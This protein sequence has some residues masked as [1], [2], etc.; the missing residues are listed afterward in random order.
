MSISG[1]LEVSILQYNSLLRSLTVRVVRGN[2][3]AARD[4][5]SLTS[6]PYFNISIR[7]DWNNVGSKRSST[8][9]G[10]FL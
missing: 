9:N 5:P 6:G 10:K 2:N 3:L 1:S 4:F 8:V 7:P